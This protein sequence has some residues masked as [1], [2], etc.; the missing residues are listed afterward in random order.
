MLQPVA[1]PNYNMKAT[2]K[3]P[4]KKTTT[5]KT[6]TKKEILQMVATLK[7]IVLQVIVK[8]VSDF[9]Q[10][11]KHMSKPEGRQIT[12]SMITS[13][14][15]DQTIQKIYK[16]SP[17]LMVD[18]MENG[19]SDRQPMYQLSVALFIRDILKD[20]SSEEM[21]WMKR[22]FPDPNINSHFCSVLNCFGAA[23]FEFIQCQVIEI[24]ALKVNKALKKSLSAS[25][26]STF[27]QRGNNI[28]SLLTLAGGSFAKIYKCVK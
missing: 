12:E 6:M 20:S 28:L 14:Q 15:L 16:K 19:P 18:C 17:E 13:R 21:V 24:K 27:I 10:A 1:K 2:K 25:S 23:V 4:K 11:E 5:K 7:T 3:K 8:C 9:S 22:K 26:E